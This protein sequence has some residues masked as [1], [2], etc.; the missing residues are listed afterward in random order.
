METVFRETNITSADTNCL[1]SINELPATI[2]ELVEYSKGLS[3]VRK[4]QKREGVVLRNMKSNISFKV[5]NPD[6]LLSE[7]V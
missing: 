2:A 1:F 6:F 4:G 3:T 7:G 5:L